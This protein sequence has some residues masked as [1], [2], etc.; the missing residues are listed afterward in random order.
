MSVLVAS[1]VATLL[2]GGFAFFAPTPIRQVEP[3]RESLP[4]ATV[5]VHVVDETGATPVSGARVTCVAIEAVREEAAR[6]W[7]DFEE[8]FD[9]V[10]LEE[11]S[12]RLGT[13][14]TTDADGNASLERPEGELRVTARVADRVGKLDVAAADGAA[15]LR[16]ARERTFDVAVDVV[17]SHGKPVEG[18]PVVLAGRCELGRTMDDAWPAGFEGVATSRAGDGRVLFRGDDAWFE[19]GR[20]G[21]RVLTFAF[22]V[23]PRVELPLDR[24]S[25]GSRRELVLPPIGRVVLSFPGVERGV[26]QLRNDAKDEHDSRP[27]W[28]DYEPARAA[29]VDGKATFPIVGVGTKLQFRATWK[30]L[31]APEEGL[32][33]GPRHDGDTVEFEAPGAAATPSFVARIL[34][35]DGRPLAGTELYVSVHRF[36][37]N[38]SESE[39]FSLTTDADG[40]ARFTVTEKETSVD[41]RT[42]LEIGVSG[43]DRS[44]AVPSQAITFEVSPLLT[45]GIHALGDLALHVPGSRKH[46]RTLSDEKLEQLFVDAREGRPF[47]SD[48]AHDADACLCEIVERGGKRWEKFLGEL[49]ASSTKQEN[50]RFDESDGTISDLRTLIALRRIQRKPEPIAL[51]VEGAPRIETVFPEEPLIRYLV[52][53]V[54][55]DGATLA[56]LTYELP[57]SGMNEYCHVEAR[58]EPGDVVP[59]HEQ[60]LVGG[61]PGFQVNIPPKEARRSSVALEY[62]LHLP[63]AGDYRARLFHGFGNSRFAY[64]EDPH[65]NWICAKSDEFTIRVLPRPIDLPRRERAR[66]RERFDAIDLEQPVVVDWRGRWKAGDAY[67]GDAASPED[68]LFRAG[69]TSVPVLLDVLEDA[70]A[71]PRA[72]AWA[73][74]LLLDVTGLFGGEHQEHSDALGRHRTV[75]DWPTVQE[76]PWQRRDR[77]SLTRVDGPEQPDVAQQAE[78]IRSWLTIR[79]S[80]AIRE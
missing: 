17:D 48:A 56:L 3:T 26:A 49:L 53:N 64:V 32:L 66:L 36:T 77:D 65:A 58:T 13:T 60:G 72:R 78:L 70:H 44:G 9:P 20:S 27:F 61:G 14:R 8:W 59:H 54:D 5:S 69:W 31:S 76:R 35:E 16:L 28:R 63:A 11:V 7:G 62:F 47:T 52:K 34:G 21:I 40:H 71:T 73:L 79:G 22:P 23:T 6:R 4:R 45:P 37:E 57:K 46:L 67:E 41:E 50:E 38:G 55:E 33:V 1:L 39:S 30:G 42:V 29:I 25:I 80:L 10:E 2:P 43:E 75:F 15:T 68:E 18:V 24:A 19:P 74:A 51:E 12:Q